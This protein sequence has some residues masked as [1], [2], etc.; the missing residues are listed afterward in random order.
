MAKLKDVHDVWRFFEDGWEPEP[1][2]RKVIEF[3]E[4]AMIRLRG[5]RVTVDDMDIV[6][7]SAKHDEP[8]FVG[9]VLFWRSSASAYWNIVPQRDFDLVPEKP[10]ALVELYPKFRELFVHVETVD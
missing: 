5:T 6:V 4:G 8:D 9:C 2:I 3:A 10:K 1:K 7:I